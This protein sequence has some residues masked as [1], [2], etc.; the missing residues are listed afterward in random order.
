MTTI[1]CIRGFVKNY[2]WRLAISNQRRFSPSLG[3]PSTTLRARLRLGKNGTGSDAEKIPTLSS[4]TR[5]TRA[6]Q[7]QIILS[8]KAL[9]GAG[10]HPSQKRP[11]D[12]AQD[13]LRMGHPRFVSWMGI[14]PLLARYSALSP[15]SMSART[16]T[17][18]RSNPRPPLG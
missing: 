15:R 9:R 7:P 1:S 18:I 4:N 8:E 11:F 13:R 10:P 12:C 14:R 17:I 6:G 3:S 16:I 2:L 5:T